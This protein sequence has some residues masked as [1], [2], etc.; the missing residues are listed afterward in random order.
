MVAMLL[1]VLACGVGVQAWRPARAHAEIARCDVTEPCSDD[2]GDGGGGYGGGGSGTGGGDWGS[3]DTG[4]G[5]YGDTSGGDD[6]D[7]G[8]A[9]YGDPGASDAGAGDYGD[10]SGS[11]YGDPGS[12]DP[13]D[14]SSGPGEESSDPTDT[15]GRDGL[16][17]PFDPTD[18][19][20]PDHYLDPSQV[21][22]TPWALPPG[23][24][25][26][27][28]S[29]SYHSIPTEGP[30]KA[31]AQDLYFKCMEGVGTPI[32]TARVDTPAP[33]PTSLAPA[34]LSR[35]AS[36]HASAPKAPHPAAPAGGVVHARP[37][38]GAHATPSAAPQ[39]SPKHAAKKPKPRPR[40]H[41]A[42]KRRIARGSH[43]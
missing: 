31:A 13:S 9:D 21:P 20:S 11:D 16:P 7:A 28:E 19:T 17:D 8:S 6:G 37:V 40:R 36:V 4:S 32:T 18:E 41:V 1:A 35:G 38:G 23:H 26:Q 2:G 43:R 24:P 10:T 29:M 15:T 5:G 14:W 3:G 34:G 25:C 22:A 27:A 33:V 12:G 39:A 30:E 42:P